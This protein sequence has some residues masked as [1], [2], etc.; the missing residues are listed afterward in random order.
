MN[1]IIKPPLK[2]IIF[3]LDGTLYK[4]K[5]FF[6]PLIFFLLFPHSTRL[7]KFL[8]ARDYFSGIEMFNEENL[9]MSISRKLAEKEKISIQDA[10]IWIKGSF[11]KAFINVMPFYRF[12]RPYAKE[13][14]LELSKKQ[15]KIAVLSDYS[16]VLERLN[17]LGYEE[18]LFNTISSCESAGALKPHPRPFVEIADRWNINPSHIL[19]IGD[20]EDTD[21]EAAKK[22]G[23]QF[24]LIS[25]KKKL[26][27]YAK[28]WN[29]IC[30]ILYSI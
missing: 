12:S 2:G 14:L 8:E 25:D 29:D 21:G 1:D 20:R 9:L 26:P 5:W 4:M 17:K 19:V 28:N 23:M 6:K 18:T 11:Y 24:I 7:L 15:I 3:D 13:I 22:A 30:K 10:L 27:K 16:K